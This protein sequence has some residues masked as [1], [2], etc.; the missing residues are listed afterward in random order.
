MKNVFTK[1]NVSAVAGK[2]KIGAKKN[3]PTLMLIGATISFGLTIYEVIKVLPKVNDILEDRRARIDSLDGDPAEEVEDVESEPVELSEEE[4]KD[5]I[6][7]I[8][9]DAAIKLGKVLW[10]PISTG[11][12][13]IGLM[14]GANYIQVKR[15]DSMTKKLADTV[16]VADISKEALKQ[17]KLATKGGV[18]EEKEKDIS[19]KADQELVNEMYEPSKT[20]NSGQGD[21]LF[22]DKQTGRLFRSTLSKVKE[23]VA[24]VRMLFDYGEFIEANILYD[25]WGLE[26]CGFGEN[27]GWM[28]GQI[29]LSLKTNET[30]KTPDGHSCIVLEYDYMEMPQYD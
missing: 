17:Y 28:P 2:M 3:A 12:T 1:E 26:E 16:A 4:K 29:E 25:Y 21:Q 24:E 15:L 8:N 7:A 20:L 22:L 6:R 11:A 18:G 27:H 9:I 13:T 14:W 30:A 19:D 23:G 10:K 5:A